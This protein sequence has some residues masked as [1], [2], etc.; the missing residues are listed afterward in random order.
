MWRQ[1]SLG[2]VVSCLLWCGW[3]WLWVR[4]KTLPE[5]LDHLDRL[6]VRASAESVPPETIAQTARAVVHRLPRFGVGE[7]LL[8]SLVTYAMLRH[9]Q[10]ADI[11]LVLGAGALDSF[12]RP[13]LHCWIEING[14]PLLEMDNLGK[15]FRVLFRHRM[16]GLA[17]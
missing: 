4:W 13:A 8:R 14:Q 17:T 2:R 16:P 15:C 9:Q 7:C 5:V 11:S 10:R 1:H 6:P 12:G 3:V